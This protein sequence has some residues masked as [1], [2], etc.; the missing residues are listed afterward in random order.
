M[1]TQ[2]STYQAENWISNTKKT[3]LVIPQSYFRYEP[4]S[5]SYDPNE[6]VH[7]YNKKSHQKIM[8]FITNFLSL[9]FRSLVFFFKKLRNQSTL[10]TIPKRKFKNSLIQPRR[11]RSNFLETSEV[12]IMKEK[13]RKG[14][15]TKK[16]ESQQILVKCHQAPAQG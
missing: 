3:H 2:R 8:T 1:I 10:S 16:M 4:I 6:F 5:L 11:S 13:I 15:V 12:R 7:F 14:Y 9:F